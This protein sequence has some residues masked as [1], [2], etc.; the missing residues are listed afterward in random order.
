MGRGGSEMPEFRVEFPQDRMEQVIGVKPLR[1]A[2]G[3]DPHAVNRG[4]NVKNGKIVLVTI[5]SP[6]SAIH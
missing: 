4:C 2:D 5:R 3:V 6:Q 1:I